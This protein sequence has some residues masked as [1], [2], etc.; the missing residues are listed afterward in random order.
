MDAAG[1]EIFATGAARMREQGVTA[2]GG[3][4]GFDDTS[5]AAA[6]TD[7]SMDPTQMQGLSKRG[8]A[9]ITALKGAKTK[10]ERE[11]AVRQFKGELDRLGREGGDTIGGEGLGGKGEAEV[12]K[13]MDAAGNIE[14]QILDQQ[15]TF[16]SLAK[17]SQNLNS[18]ATALNKAQQAVLLKNKIPPTGGF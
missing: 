10:E 7:I 15:T 11:Q 17:A 16:A 8:R 4:Q 5:L 18:A 9:S 13:R 1:Q 12:Q 6:M 14:G 3:V 2:L